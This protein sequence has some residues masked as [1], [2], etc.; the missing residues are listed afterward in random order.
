MNWNKILSVFI[1]IFLVINLGLYG[2]R[3]IRDQRSYTLSNNRTRQLETMMK[4]KG[5]T[6]YDYLPEFYPKAILELKS[7][8]WKKEEILAKIFG[9]QDYRSEITYQAALADSYQNDRQQLAF[10]TGDHSGT[11]YYKGENERYVPDSSALS[12]LE[13]KALLFVRDL[14]GDGKQFQVTNRQVK[15]SE[16]LLD[17]NGV[18][19]GQIIFSSQFQV[20]IGEK[21]ISEAIGHFYEPLEFDGAAQ[22]IY[23]FDE[24]MYYFMNKMEEKGKKNIIIK[25]ADIGYWILDSDTRQLTIEATPVYRLILED[26]SIYYIDAYQNEFLNAE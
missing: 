15:G 20:Q 21:G 3:S 11:L 25:D 8:E 4:Q 19:R 7:A 5:V 16:Y 22:E 26:G 17:I 24:V 1:V 10:Y 6:M 23:A 18:F 13:A 12:A 14:V 2:V 9:G